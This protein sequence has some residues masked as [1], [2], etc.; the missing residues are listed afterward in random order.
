M[1]MAWC[2]PAVLCSH[3]SPTRHLWT[4]RRPSLLPG[5]P[6]TIWLF[7]RHT[8][9]GSWLLAFALVVLL[10]GTPFSNV[11]TLAQM[12]PPQR[13]AMGLFLYDSGRWVC[14]CCVFTVLPPS[15]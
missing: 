12:S 5:L 14:N 1:W 8:K 7:P 11:P 9:L 13:H 6:A 3:S 4:G 2:Y 10:L 15:A